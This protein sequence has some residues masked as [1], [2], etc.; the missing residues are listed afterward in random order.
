MS[1]QLQPIT[2]ARPFNLIVS[3]YVLLPAGHGGLKC[4]L[5][6][7]DVYS[8]FI[9]VTP[10]RGPGTG[11][12]TLP[13]DC[14]EVHNWAKSRNVQPLKTPPYAP[15]ANGLAE[16]S[17]KLIIGRLKCLCTPTVRESPD[18]DADASTTPAAWPKHLAT[19]VSQLN[20]RAL[21]S[22]GGYSPCELLTGQLKAERC[23]QLSHPVTEP[24]SE[25]VDVNLAL[26]Y[27]LQQDGF[28]KALEHANRCKRQFNKHV[29][30]VSFQTGDLVQHY[31]ARWDETHAAEHKLAP[32]WSGLL[33]VC[34]R[35]TN[36]YKLE[37]LHGN[38]F[39]SAAHSRLLRPFIPRPN[40]PLAAYAEGLQTAHVQDATATHPS[41]PV[42]ASTLPA[43]PRPESRFPLKRKDETQPK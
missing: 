33:R 42:E 2:R 31:N 3:D 26:T 23:Y 30:P 19:A 7:V 21:P 10:L 38:L 25:Q 34:S 5:V 29:K 16:G 36:S 22:L 13:F 27:A 32:R 43:T 11:K 40:T 39:A 6:F 24:T 15:W 12:T 18:E 14:A 1:A 37:D 17:I 9:F 20:D 28:A 8:Q 35:A 41:K 4:V